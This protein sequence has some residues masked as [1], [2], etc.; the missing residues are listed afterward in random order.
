MD[1]PNSQLTLQ[2]LH[3]GRGC[4]GDVPSLRPALQEKLG[5]RLL[6][7]HEDGSDRVT[8]S[9]AAALL[10]DKLS[11]LTVD[12][13]SFSSLEGFSAG[14]TTDDIEVSGGT[15]QSAPSP[16]APMPSQYPLIL[17]SSER[18]HLSLCAAMPGLS[19]R[20]FRLDHFGFLGIHNDQNSVGLGGESTR[21]SAIQARVSHWS[22]CLA[23]LLNASRRS[24]AGPAVRQ[25]SM[26]SRQLA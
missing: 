4:G 5:Y 24:Q 21:E 18:L 9:A 25:G 13:V 3:R 15:M 14:V 10:A 26:T 12:I 16:M 19:D 22:T 23:H 7:V 8:S 17:V 1:W 11:G 6:L 2:S 20:V